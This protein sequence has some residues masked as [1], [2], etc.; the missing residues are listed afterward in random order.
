M[1]L[2][3]KGHHK[4]AKLCFTGH[5][6]MENRNG[7]PVDVTLTQATDIAERES[8]LDM[9]KDAHGSRR[10]TLGA[11]KGYDCFHLQSMARKGFNTMSV[12]GYDV[13]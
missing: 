9:I 10:V 7:M 2:S 11:D 3:K 4:E 5:V 13:G 12:I 8:A 6:L 1:I